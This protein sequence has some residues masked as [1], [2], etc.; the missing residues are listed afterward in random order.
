M[1]QNK[2]LS[3]LS[4]LSPVCCSI[5]MR[6]Q[7]CRSFDDRVVTGDKVA[8]D[9]LRRLFHGLISEISSS[10]WKIVDQ[11]CV[12]W[13]GSPAAL[14]TGCAENQSSTSTRWSART[15]SAAN[16]VCLPTDV[17]RKANK[18]RPIARAG[19]YK[20]A[21]N[22]VRLEVG[23]C[24]N[25]RGAGEPAKLAEMPSA[26]PKKTPTHAGWPRISNLVLIFEVIAI[27]RAALPTNVGCRR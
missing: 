18:P 21:R 1:Q 11:H 15:K 4:P 14:A 20:Y 8:R 2:G 23:E 7:G 9:D 26:Q 12:C 3:P 10:T 19:D 6:M 27:F 13:R 5:H 25:D 16:T 22:A 17:Q 24:A